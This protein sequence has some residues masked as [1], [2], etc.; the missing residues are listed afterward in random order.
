MVVFDMTK[1]TPGDDSKGL[2]HLSALSEVNYDIY[3]LSGV[4][5]PIGSC[6][7]RRHA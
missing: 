1:K 5:R 2:F 6:K 4:Q 3:D 7:W